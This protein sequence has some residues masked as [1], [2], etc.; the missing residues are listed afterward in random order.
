MKVR[1]QH[2]LPEEEKTGSCGITLA[3]NGTEKKSMRFK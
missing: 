1:K 2:K 3:F